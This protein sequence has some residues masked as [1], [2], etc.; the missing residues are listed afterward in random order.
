MFHL[1]LIAPLSGWSTE[2]FI[3][4]Y[5]APRKVTSWEGVLFIY[6]KTHG[7]VGIRRNEF[8]FNIEKVH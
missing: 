6:L 7:G 5:I 2:V 8:F 1:S 4:V 3:R